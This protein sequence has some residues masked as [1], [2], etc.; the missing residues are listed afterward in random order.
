MPLEPW[1]LRL[2]W[3]AQTLSWGEHDLVVPK[4]V[5]PLLAYLSLPGISEG[6][7]PDPQTR[8]HLAKLGG[9]NES[10][11]RAQVYRLIK[12]SQEGFGRSPLVSTGISF[13]WDRREVAS[14][15]WAE[16]LTTVL[17]ALT[18]PARALGSEAVL[19]RLLEAEHRF[20]LG[21]YPEV[22]T[23]LLACLELDPSAEQEV[24]IRALG[25]WAALRLSNDGAKMARETQDFARWF[26]ALDTPSR[27]LDNLTRARA[28]IQQARTPMVY[29][30]RGAASKLFN[31]AAELLP[32]WAWRERSSVQA[33]LGYVELKH[34][35]LERA[36]QH[37]REALQL[38]AYARWSWSVQVQ[39]GN[40][41]EVLYESA[42]G[43]PHLTPD[44]NDPRLVE[45]DLLLEQAQ[46]LCSLYGYRGSGDTELYR[47]RIAVWQNRLED[48]ETLIALAFASMDGPEPEYDYPLAIEV[49]AELLW[50]RGEQARAISNLK[51]ALD[52]E[53]KLG[54]EVDAPRLEARLCYWEKVSGLSRS[55]V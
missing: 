44:A 36:E 52:L 14:I 45:S 2:S 35:A 11:Q 32:E 15:H 54:T 25:L 23:V 21:Q 16:P 31:K 38:A 7:A 39:L 30:K 12:A 55:S 49:R 43:K 34:G 53:R 40:L 22:Q 24:R 20:E 10:S 50:K 26:R 6:S 47:A 13:V 29:Q 19:L 51:A 9:V 46:K 48:A 8:A 27:G 33:G 42:R 1:P 41:A 4:S 37:F 17:S 28:L 18:P 3:T 5:F